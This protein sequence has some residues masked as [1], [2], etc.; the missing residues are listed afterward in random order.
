[1]DFA[2][3]ISGFCDGEG[4]FRTRFNQAN[5]RY[6]VSFRIKVREDDRKIIHRIQ[7]YFNCG[8]VGLDKCRKNPA[9]YIEVNRPV[10]CRDILLKHFRSSPLMSKKRIEFDYWARAVEISAT[11]TERKSVGIGYGGGTK[12][13]WADAEINEFKFLHE[14]IKECRA[15]DAEKSYAVPHADHE[16]FCSWL[17]GFIDAEGSLNINVSE[18]KTGSS[19]G[20][21]RR[22][23]AFNLRL[24]CD[25]GPIIETIQGRLGVG[26]MHLD[27]QERAKRY[28]VNS[29]P[30][31]N[32]LVGGINQ[33]H[34]I[35]VPLLEK[36]PLQAKKHNDFEIW[37]RA[38]AISYRIS[39]MPVTTNGYLKGRKS[40]WDEKSIQ[41]F[42]G[43]WR[44]LKE[45]RKYSPCAA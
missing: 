45:S 27:K 32:L 23:C 20:Y 39:Q 6:G 44:E 12:K 5:S 2:K 38:V 30:A 10:H 24:R 3:Y 18:Y 7:D 34:D 29:K 43:L 31:F 13:K 1:M 40:N 33:L 36:Y 15:F 35:I 9:I 16:S 19:S 42:D 14:K 28:G 4:C 37:K 41:E 21:T 25:D 11:C 22:N 26:S 8:N 17:S